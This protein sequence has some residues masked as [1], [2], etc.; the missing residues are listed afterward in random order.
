[1][2]DKD[3]LLEDA[4]RLFSKGLVERLES[5]GHDIIEAGR[6]GA[7]IIDSDGNRYIDGYA[8]GS[9]YN[10][11]R[12]HPEILEELERAGRETDQGSFI[13]VSK[14]KAR[15]VGRLTEFIPGNYT[16]VLLSPAR[17]EGFDAACKL[18]RGHTGRPGLVSVEGGFHGMT[19]FAISLS[20]ASDKDRFGSLIPETNIIPHG[21]LDAAKQAITDKTAAFFI[22]PVQAENNCRIAEPD[23]V[24]GLR[25]L[26]D[27]KGA[28]LVF[29]ETQSGFGRTGYKFATEHLGVFPD[30]LIFG[31]AV[32]SGVFPMVGSVFTRAIKGFFD[33]HPLIHMHTF[34]GH[35]VGCRVSYKALEVY[36]QLKPWENARKMGEK[37]RKGLQE[38]A[39]RHPEAI[40]SVSGLGLLIS[41][42]LRSQDAAEKFCR[43][44][45]QKGMLVKPGLVDKSCVP[46]RPVL[47]ITDEEAGNILNCV[48]DAAGEIQD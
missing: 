36:D 9:T 2:S 26:C 34:G 38:I 37:L 48:S 8:S 32:N 7:F 11:G 46:I 18:A 30:I 22:E 12:K 47:V 14:E 6:E 27:Q 20:S 28:L 39:G 16:G 19:G 42:K 25:E 43:A 24:R 15:L 21:D 41:I 5:L 45:R 3:Q 29:D 35:D 13:L 10:L 17:G 4:K 31:E 1:M 40:E 33:E 23:Y 44:A